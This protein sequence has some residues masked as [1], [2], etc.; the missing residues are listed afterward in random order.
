MGFWLMP[1]PEASLSGQIH[2]PHHDDVI[3]FVRILSSL[4][5]SNIVD[6]NFTLQSPAFAS[7]SNPDKEQLLGKSDGGTAPEWDRYAASQG[8]DHFWETELR[9]YGPPKIIAAKWAYVKERFAAIGGV[10]FVDGETLHFPLTDEQI[11]KRA[12]VTFFGIPSLS[13]FSGMAGGGGL[14]GEPGALQ[15]TGHLDASPLV[16]ISGEALLKAQRA[17]NKVFQ[18]AG[19]PRGLG[20]AMNYHWRTFIMFQGLQITNDKAHNAKVRAAYERCAQVAV[21]NGWGFYR[22]HNAFHDKVMSLLSFNDH[23][24]PKLHETLKDALDPNGILSAGRYGIWPR[25]LRR[26]HT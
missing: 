24:L 3:P 17:F 20:F 1:E 15:T 9:F 12:D 26:S 22:A 23:A 6:C 19:L 4:M 2:V 8:L 18:E 16:P 21:E 13:V 25:H 7:P 14:T 5:Y 11:E 10:R